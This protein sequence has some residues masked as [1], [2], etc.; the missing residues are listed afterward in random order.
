LKSN[1]DSDK[2]DFESHLKQLQGIC[3]PIIS[4]V[5]KKH[6]GSQGG[7][8]GYEDEDHEDL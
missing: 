1:E 5:Y 4:A 6:G 3:D 2:D 8:E 7:S